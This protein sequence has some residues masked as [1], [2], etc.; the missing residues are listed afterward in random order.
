MRPLV[1]YRMVEV[2]DNTPFK[3]RVRQVVIALLK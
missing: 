1:I 2:G 3:E